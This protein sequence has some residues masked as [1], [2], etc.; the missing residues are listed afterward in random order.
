M[1][2]VR[3]ADPAVVP[4][5]VCVVLAVVHRV[6]T[7][8]LGTTPIVLSRS[9]QQISGVTSCDRTS[10]TDEPWPNGA[11]EALHWDGR[12]VWSPAHRRAAV[13][14]GTTRCDPCSSLIKPLVHICSVF[15]HDGNI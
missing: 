7:D 15:A 14:V 5:H 6:E 10:I 13:E 11:L 3:T 1:V 4:P 2:V 9:A 12:L 8:A